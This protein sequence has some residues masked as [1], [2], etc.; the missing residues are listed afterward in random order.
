MLGPIV[1]GLVYGLSKY[2]LS[3]IIPG[4]Q[5]LIFAPI[6]IIIIIL[7]PEGIIGMIKKGTKGKWIKRYIIY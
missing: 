4:F 2:Y 6:V 1:G 3:V 7:F 5:L